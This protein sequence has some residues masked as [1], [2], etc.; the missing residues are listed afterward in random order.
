MRR[1]LFGRDEFAGGEEMG[2]GE[3]SVG[4]LVGD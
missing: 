1:Q 4:D 3:G 2:D